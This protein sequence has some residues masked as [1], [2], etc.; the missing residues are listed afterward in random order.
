MPPQ[1]RQAQPASRRQRQLDRRQRL[2]EAALEEFS[3]H[4]P[5]GARVD[6][7]SQRAGVNPQLITYYFGGKAGLYRET[8]RWCFGR[9]AGP[10]P[11]ESLA[12]LLSEFF[13]SVI[14]DPGTTRL[15]QWEALA[16][17]DP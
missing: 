1:S 15:L 17:A 9:A 12:G 5:A 13:Q 6:A 7:I 16:Q 3:L 2:L 8:V 4:G 11:S 10:A 14:A